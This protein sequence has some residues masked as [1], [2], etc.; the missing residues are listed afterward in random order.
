MVLYYSS[1]RKLVNRIWLRKNISV[2]KGTLVLP[3]QR[4]HQIAHQL[5]LPFLGPKVPTVL[6]R[7]KQ[8]LVTVGIGGGG[9]NW[10]D[11]LVQPLLACC[12]GLRCFLCGVSVITAL[13]AKGSTDVLKLPQGPCGAE[14]VQGQS[15]VPVVPVGRG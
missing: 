10:L 7:P 1:L 2:R 15:S 8:T 11:H 4:L 9:R 14:S 3:I 5:R 12:S 13:A 6:P